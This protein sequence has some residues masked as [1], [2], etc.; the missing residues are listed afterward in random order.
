[1]KCGARPGSGKATSS[2]AIGLG[3]RARTSWRGALD[4]VGPSQSFR[5]Y[6]ERDGQ[7]SFTD[8]AFR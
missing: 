8:L 2:S 7:L 3:S 4:R 6:F 1:M 5:L